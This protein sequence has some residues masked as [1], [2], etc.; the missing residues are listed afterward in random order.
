MSYA[1]EI[2]VALVNVLKHACDGSNEYFAGY[3]ANRRFW[4]AEARHCL[5]VI[6]GYDER[7][8]RMTEASK[9]FRGPKFDWPTIPIERRSTRSTD[10]SAMRQTLLDSMRRFLARCQKLFPQDAQAIDR[11]AKSLGVPTPL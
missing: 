10:L 5:D 7:F 8:Q 4:V 9:A 11:D 1:I 2:G 3:A 6:T